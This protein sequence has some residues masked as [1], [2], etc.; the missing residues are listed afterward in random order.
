MFNFCMSQSL[1]FNLVPIKGLEHLMK[2][3]SKTFFFVRNVMFILYMSSLSY[4]PAVT[5]SNWDNTCNRVLKTY[6]PCEDLSNS[7]RINM[8]QFIWFYKP[9]AV[10][11]MIK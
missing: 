9:I 6:F 3:F 1:I 5:S 4:I 2:S 11:T 7:I 10:K 8:M